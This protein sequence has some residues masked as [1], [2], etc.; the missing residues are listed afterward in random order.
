MKFTSAATLLIIFIACSAHGQTSQKNHYSAASTPA[1]RIKALKNQV[2]NQQAEIDALRLR[3]GTL[4]QEVQE[5]SDILS[6]QNTDS[7]NDDDSTDNSGQ[8]VLL[9]RDH[10]RQSRRNATRIARSVSFVQTYA[11][12]ADCQPHEIRCRPITRYSAILEPWFH[13]H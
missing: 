6:E 12:P 13:G 8:P 3:L 5:L 2:E 4:Q 1:L 11:G 9:A 7:D 10:T